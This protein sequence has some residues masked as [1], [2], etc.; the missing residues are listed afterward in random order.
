MSKKYRIP[1]ENLHKKRLGKNTLIKKVVSR[2]DI[3]IGDMGGFHYTSL[4]GLKGILET[5]TLY[6]TDCEFLNDASERININK[7]LDDFWY[8]ERNNYDKDFKNLIKSIRFKEYQDNAY[9]LIDNEFSNV[10][11]RYFVLSCSYDGDSLNMWKYYSKGNE[12]NG[13]CIELFTPALTDEWIDRVTGVAVE[14]GSVIYSDDEK[15]DKIKIAVEKL[16]EVWCIYKRSKEMDDKIINEFTCWIQIASLFFKDKHF[17]GEKEKRYIA[18]VPVS[19]LN[20]I[21]YEYNEKV[22]KMYDFRISNGMLIPFIKMPFNTY[23]V[24]NCYS[25][26]SIRVGPSGNFEQK[27]EGICRFIESLD[28]NM[29]IPRIIKSEIPLRD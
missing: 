27:K 4:E 7:T 2:Y 15:F 8:Y 1:E 25:I 20:Q 11:C 23:H 9:S 17:E 24:E 6:F 12:Y 16:Y 5:R 19:I 29:E 14:S 26:E 13:Y 10:P 18:I 3:T 21:E 22:Y 28:Y